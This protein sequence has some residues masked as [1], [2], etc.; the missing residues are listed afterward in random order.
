MTGRT[1]VGQLIEAWL[2]DR[3]GIDVLNLELLW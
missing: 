3:P 2:K 1:D